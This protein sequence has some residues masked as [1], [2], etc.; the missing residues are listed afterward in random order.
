M[1]SITATPRPSVSSISP[2]GPATSSRQSSRPRNRWRSSSDS[3]SNR[4]SSAARPQIICSW[5]ATSSASSRRRSAHSSAAACESAWVTHGRPALTWSAANAS[6]IASD[7]WLPRAATASP[8]RTRPLV[9]HRYRDRDF[10]L[11]RLL[12]L[13]DLGGVAL[14]L[15]FAMLVVGYREHPWLD[16]SLVLLTLPGWGLLFRVYGLYEHQMRRFEPTWIDDLWPLFHAL[17]VG[18]L[19]TWL[20]YKV[21]AA[22]PL[23]LAEVATFGITAAVAIAGLRVA[24]RSL[25]LRIRGPERVLV[26]GD[27][28]AVEAIARKLRNH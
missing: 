17:M 15:F 3:S 20:T 21:L 23:I 26:V 1:A 18:T 14:A 25:H 5:Y 16:G 19:A 8:G 2:T 22:S 7:T 10:L 13:A 9:S 4:C 27:A 11:R 12:L 28:A 6:G 24:V